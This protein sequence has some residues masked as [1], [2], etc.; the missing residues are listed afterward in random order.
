MRQQSVKALH[1]HLRIIGTGLAHHGNALLQREQRL[2]VMAC[3]HGHDDL[4][5]Q[6]CSPAHHIFMPQRDRV[7][8]SGVNSNQVL[9]HGL[10]LSCGS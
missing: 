8:G 7:K 10:S 3:R 2:F 6:L 5:K 9:A 4:A 1:L